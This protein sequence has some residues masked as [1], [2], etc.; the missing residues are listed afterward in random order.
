MWYSW[1]TLDR[2]VRALLAKRMERD[3]LDRKVMARIAAR[4]RS[5]A[6]G[7]ERTVAT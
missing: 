7:G 2:R 6:Q 4:A 5:R 1:I 3:D